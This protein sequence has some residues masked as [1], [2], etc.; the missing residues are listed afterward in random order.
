MITKFKDFDS[1][2]ENM[3]KARAVLRQ[4]GKTQTNPDFVKLRNLLSNNMGYIGKF[5]EWMF[6]KNISYD[7]LESL[8]NRIKDARLS[9]P[10]DQFETPEEVIDTLIRKNS[11][12][13]LNQM[14][15]A[16][17]SN[18]RQF[19]KECDDFKNLENFLTQHS[20][21][22]VAIIDFFSKKSGRYG[23]YDEDEV[24]ENII[25]DLEYVV[26]VKSISEI[27][28]FSK[29]SDNIKFIHE[30]NKLLIVAVNY[31]GIQEVGSRY[32][33]IVQDEYTFDEYVLNGEAK[34]QLVIYFKD[35]IPEEI[36]AP[37]V[38]I[39]FPE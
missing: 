22:K 15:N 29:K 32:W 37:N 17:P 12:S 39:K 9:K 4:S 24:I 10:I 20:N 1:I 6:L 16:I 2:N 33:C 14:I 35:K 36:S 26:N 3:S 28:Q 18:T 19:L 25:K 7:Q 23:E 27:A 21:K 31:Q 5:T 38:P 34:I 13:D 30:D 8:Y 11:Q